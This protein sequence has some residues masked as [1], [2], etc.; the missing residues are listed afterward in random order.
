MLLRPIFQRK[1]LTKE[2]VILF[3]LHWVVHQFDDCCLKIHYV[4][5]AIR[6]IACRKYDTLGGK[7]LIAKQQKIYFKIPSPW[8]CNSRPQLKNIVIPENAI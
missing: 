5:N 7:P 2:V 1:L 6:I 8:S 3:T 4:N